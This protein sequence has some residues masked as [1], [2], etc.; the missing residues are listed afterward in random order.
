MFLIKHQHDALLEHEIFFPSK[1]QEIIYWTWLK[2]LLYTL[3]H[4]GYS[5]ESSESTTFFISTDE[6]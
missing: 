2:F 5:I 3:D 4:S 1:S 6:Y